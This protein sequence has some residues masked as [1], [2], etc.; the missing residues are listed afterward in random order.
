MGGV[1]GPLAASRSGRWT[2]TVPG[3]LERYTS[4]GHGLRRELS[5]PVLSGLTGV[6]GGGPR[7]PSVSP[8]GFT[9]DDLRESLRGCLSPVRSSLFFGGGCPACPRKR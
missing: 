3:L 8:T 9:G 2:G 4:T 5:P 6:M 7:R 1:H